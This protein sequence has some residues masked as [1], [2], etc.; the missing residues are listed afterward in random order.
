MSEVKRSR[1]EK[2]EDYGLVSVIM[3]SYNSAK[4]IGEAV[5]SVLNQ[6]YKNWELIIIDDCSTDSSLNVLEKYNDNRIRVLKNKENNGAAVTRNKGLEVANGRY[7]AFLDCD[8]VWHR[9]KLWL[10][11]KFMV[12]NEY[13]FVCTDYTVVKEDNDFV[14]EYVPKK[15]SYRYKNILKHN[16]IGCSTVVL[17]RDFL[18]DVLMPVNA[19]K[20]ED[21]ACWLKILRHGRRAYVLHRSLTIYRR[22]DSSV[23][24]RKAKM[25]KYQW[26]VYRKVE[27]LSFIKSLYY[28]AHWAI[29]GVFKYK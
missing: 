27:R 23:S 29:K 5:D 12:E 9:D 25:A 13:I 4:Y 6:T 16:C 20:R 22:R 15:D 10:S 1:R 2:I 18:G 8:D 19:P 28:L 3:P 14:T 26:N 24:S 11:L 21:F 7:V 17:D